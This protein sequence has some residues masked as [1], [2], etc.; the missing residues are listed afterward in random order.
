MASE[1]DAI[2]ILEAA[3]ELLQA[4]L[5]ERIIE[6][7]GE[8]LDDAGGE[9]Y[10]GPIEA[11]H[12][13]LGVKLAQVN[14]LLG[15]LTS[16][17]ASAPSRESVVAEPEPHAAAPAGKPPNWLQFVLEI[18]ADSRLEAARTLMA[19]FG[20]LPAR[21][22]ACAERFRDR[23]SVDPA[24]LGR[25]LELGRLAGAESPAAALELLA[26]GFGLSGP[27]AAAALARLRSLRAAG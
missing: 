18:Q 10:G 1:R 21:A 14:L 9:S 4:R 24:L 7:R 26:E 13:Q 3:R 11:V 25:V 22:A 17:E 23:Q 5:V 27:E 12:D 8:L 20:L 15:T 16:G 2:R 19:L 6:S